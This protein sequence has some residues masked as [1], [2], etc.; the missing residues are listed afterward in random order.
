VKI[1]DKYILEEI[2][3]KLGKYFPNNG[4]DIRDCLSNLYQIMQ[5]IEMLPETHKLKA[6]P[7]TIKEFNL[8]KSKMFGFDIIAGDFLP[9]VHSNLP[10]ELAFSWAQEL[11]LCLWDQYL[12]HDLNGRSVL[13]MVRSE[14]E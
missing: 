4:V 12:L 5:R 1:L 14:P 8:E 11:N 13:K 2:V 6:K 9:P 10:E 3:E 7:V